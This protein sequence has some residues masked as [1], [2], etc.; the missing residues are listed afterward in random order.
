MNRIVFAALAGASLLVVGNAL[1]Q[2]APNF[3]TVQII[4]TDLG[5]NTWMLKGQGMTV[6]DSNLIV[7]AGKDGVILVDTMYAPLHD[8]VKAAIKG[9]SDQPVKYVVNTHYHGDHTGGNQAFWLDGATVVANENVNKRLEEGVTNA[10]TGVKTPPVGR[11]GQANKTYTEGLTLSVKGRTARLVHMHNAHTDGDTA[12]FFPDANVLAAGDIVSTGNRY[13]NIDVAAGGNINGMIKAV[14]VYIARS[15]DKTKVV[16]GH[17][18]LT[19]KAGLRAYR[20]M[21]A[22]ARDGVA[23]MMKDGKTEDEIVAAKPL[24]DVQVKAGANDMATA[25]FERLIYRSLKP[26]A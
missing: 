3:A 22:E 17:G 8:K 15:N 9:L 25:T 24:T 23:K 2:Q 18:A 11:G 4:A 20:A 7:A 6:G 12:V 19:D 26:K 13:P 1:A 16:P 5:H 14:D 10:L 21:L